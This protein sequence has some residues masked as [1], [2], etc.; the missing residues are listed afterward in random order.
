MEQFREFT[1][2]SKEHQ[3]RV[4][5]RFVLNEKINIAC[6]VEISPED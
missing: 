6:R 2:L 4:P 1:L 3:S 5:I